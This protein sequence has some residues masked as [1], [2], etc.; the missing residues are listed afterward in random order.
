VLVIVYSRGINIRTH[1]HTS[2]RSNTELLDCHLHAI[3]KL[4][5]IVY[6]GFIITGILST[7]NG[8]RLS[9]FKNFLN[10]VKIPVMLKIQMT[11]DSVHV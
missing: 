3:L 2:L 9:G 5:L 4:F 11:S 7:N 6:S 10:S 1:E 8:G